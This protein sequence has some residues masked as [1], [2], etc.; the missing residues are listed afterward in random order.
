[1]KALWQFLNST[2]LAIW[3]T[4]LISLDVLIGTFLLSG[5]ADRLLGINLELFLPW[6]FGPG[7]SEL[8]ITWWLFLLFPLVGLLAISTLA[9][10]I[11]SLRTLAGKKQAHSATRRLLAQLTHVGFVIVLMGHVITS[12]TGVRTQGNQIA[13]GE[14]MKLPGAADLELRLDK[15]DVSY[16]GAGMMADMAASTSL[17]RDGEL[18]RQSVIKLNQPLIQNGVAVYISHHGETMKGLKIRVS[19]DGTDQMLGV[20]LGR[21]GE[22]RFGDYRIATGRM[23]PD[24]AWDDSG[25]AYSVSGEVRN[26]ALELKLY[27]AGRQVQN[28]WIELKSPEKPALEFAGYRFFYAGVEQSAYGVFAINRDPGALVALVGG[29]LFVAALLLLL[30]TRGSKAELV[31]PGRA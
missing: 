4:V 8:S 14:S 18:L 17:F 28:G 20:P 30:F 23:L 26:P 15:M 13:E 2:R 31:M 25:K 11:E 16:S 10:I 6:L 12:S 9:T 7:V 29:V 5:F 19:G 22:A 3:L 24:L 27:Q 1:M 21:G